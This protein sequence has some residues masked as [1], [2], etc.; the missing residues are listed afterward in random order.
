[1]GSGVGLSDGAGVGFEE[2]RSSRLRSNSMSG[3]GSIK[4][5]L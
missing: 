4:A 3:S 1:M 5:I 2:G